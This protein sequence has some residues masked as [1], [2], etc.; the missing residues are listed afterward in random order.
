MPSRTSTGTATRRGGGGGACPPSSRD[1]SCR[2]LLHLYLRFWNQI[3]TWVDVSF[4][5]LARCSRSGADRYRC[6]LN[7]RSSSK[8]WA[9][10][11]RTRGFRRLR[12]F[13]LSLSSTA[14]QSPAASR[15]FFSWQLSA[16]EA[17]QQRLLVVPG[18]SAAPIQERCDPFWWQRG[19]CSNNCLG[20]GEGL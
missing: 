10:E 4:K 13:G 12:G 9:C 6:C 16:E 7:L 8:T 2:C 11:K 20:F 19:A 18:L 14:L 1:L 5:L 17:K 15:G 3:F